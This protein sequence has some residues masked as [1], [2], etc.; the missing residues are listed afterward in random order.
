MAETAAA[1]APNPDADGLVGQIIEWPCEELPSAKYRWCDGTVVLRD[2][3]PLLFARIKTRFN[4]SGELS[5]EFRL[6]NKRSRIA[7]GHNPDEADFDTVGETGGTKAATMPTHGHNVSGAPSIGTL[8]VSD[9]GHAHSYNDHWA[10]SNGV[11]QAPSPEGWFPYSRNNITSRTTSS[12]TAGVTLTGA[13]GVGSLN[14]ADAAGSGNNMPPYV[15]IPFI[16]KV[17]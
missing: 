4:T 12:S 8:A 7:V 11:N 3:F 2:E 10:D 1:V 17:L 9:P 15:V 6:P 5:T 16:I 13:P 14:V